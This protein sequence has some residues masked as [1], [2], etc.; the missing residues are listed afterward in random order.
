M[1]S[2]FIFIER[3]DAESETPTLWPPDTRNW[4]TGKDPDA[5]KD[6]RLEE[7][8]M[9]EDEMV[10]WRHQLGGHELKQATRVG[11]RQGSLVCCSPWGWKKSDTTYWTELNWTELLIQLRKWIILINCH[12]ESFQ[13]FLT[14]VRFL[15]TYLLFPMQR[16]LKIPHNCTHLTC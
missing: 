14:K 15:N 4:L 3:I 6:W 7:R 11:E 12:F 16:M 8:G 1:K 5:R 2:V 9:T 10:G 13:L